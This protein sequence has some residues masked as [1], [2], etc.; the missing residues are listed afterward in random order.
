MNS[1]FAAAVAAVLAVVG[2]LAGCATEAEVQQL[3]AEDLA[4][5]QELDRQFVEAIS[6]KDVEKVMSLLWNSPHFVLVTPDGT[7]HLGWEN[8]RKALQ[9]MLAG[10]ESVRLEI[11]EVTHARSGDCVLAVGTATYQMQPMDGPP[12]QFTERWTDV[13]RKIGGRWVYVLDHAHA[14]PPS[15]P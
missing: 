13:R 4:A 9:E 6:Q 1:T 14:L 5:N 12:L 15:G 2:L 11:N 10:L 8:A 3:S 7:V